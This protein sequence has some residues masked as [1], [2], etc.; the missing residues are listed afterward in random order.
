MTG[1]TNRGSEIGSDPI[2]RIIAEEAGVAVPPQVTAAARV[3]CAALGDTVGAILFYGSALRDGDIEG[4]VIDL[5][6]LVDRYRTAYDTMPPAVANWVLPPNVYYL[7]AQGG[8]RVVRIKYAVISFDQFARQ[9]SGRAFTPYIWARFAQPTAVVYARDAGC[10]DRAVAA[11]RRAALTLMRNG[12]P[13]MP[14]EFSSGDFWPRVLRESYRTELRAETGAKA[15]ELYDRN[16][17][18]YDAMLDAASALRLGYRQAGAGVGAGS[19]G[20]GKYLRTAAGLRVLATRA[21]WL[22]RRPVGKILSLLRLVKAAF[23]FS[24]GV[25]YI[26]WKVERHSGVKVTATDWQRR[27]PLM[28]AT[29]LA[30]R[31]YVRR[32]FR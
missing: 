27:H 17:D 10:R 14:P 11:L 26:L 16:R 12:A 5:Y 9:A 24:H 3:V 2:A 4:K 19:G 25:D 22:A 29:V 1:N 20:G 7:S 18:R 15:L 23:T 30:W 6:A 13:L 31:L 21:A 32:G 8:G 28:A